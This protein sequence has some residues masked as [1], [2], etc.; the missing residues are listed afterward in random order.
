[1]KKLYN[2][3]VKTIVK[4]PY[5]IVEDN[6]F[7]EFNVYCPARQSQFLIIGVPKDKPTYTQ[8]SIDYIKSRIKD[9]NINLYLFC[10]L[11]EIGHFSTY[12]KK[13]CKREKKYYTRFEKTN[14]ITLANN[15][16]KKLICEKLADGWANQFIQKNPQLVNEWNS[17]IME[18]LE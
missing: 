16:H 7:F 13:I 17:K 3:I 8:G 11:H 2:E 4:V 14:N 12:N 10:L 15:I 9:K 18:I 6:E 1:M 5:K